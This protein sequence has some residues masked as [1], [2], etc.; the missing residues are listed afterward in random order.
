MDPRDLR[1]PHPPSLSPRA[2]AIAG[3]AAFL[4]AGALF[5]AIAWNVLNPTPLILLDISVATWLHASP[6]PVLTRF[7]FGVTELHSMLGLSV[8]CV[9]FALV[10]AKLREW[11]WM[12]TLGLAVGGGML[13]N[14]LLK[15]AYER[16]RPHFDDPLL[17][18]TSYSFPSGHTSGAVLFYGVLAA[19]L[20]SRVYSRRW[21]ATIVGA[22]ITAVVL[23]AFSRVYLGAHYLTDVLAAACSSAAWLV[24]CLSFVHEL[25]R[26]RTQAVAK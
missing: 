16:T 9:V 17:V 12:L 1:A 7:L 13:L 19:F 3:W 25:V 8:L 24:L 22:A 15:Y 20:V 23:V 21:R 11:Y 26:R 4:L 10:L 14:V 5:L 2:L 18:L 6:R